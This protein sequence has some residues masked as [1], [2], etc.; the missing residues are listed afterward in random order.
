MVRTTS[1]GLRQHWREVRDLPEGWRPGITVGPRR[2]HADGGPGK[3]AWV[4][5]G[6]FLE[7]LALVNTF[8]RPE[9]DSDRNLLGYS[10]AGWW[11]GVLAGL[12]F[13]PARVLW[14]C[15]P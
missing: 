15:S 4:S 5:K 12:G 1:G 2:H 13:I 10:R 11:G 8:A 14:R 3:R 7:G 6:Q 9:W